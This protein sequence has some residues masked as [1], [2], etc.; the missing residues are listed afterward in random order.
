MHG[1]EIFDFSKRDGE[2][3]KTGKE[4]APEFKVFPVNVDTDFWDERYLKENNDRLFVE[5]H[6]RKDGGFTEFFSLL[7]PG[8]YSIT[9]KKY[10][11]SNEYLATFIVP[12]AQE[13]T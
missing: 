9:F 6:E 10:E 11:D 7:C 5:I 1:E 13:F 12:D 8:K 4:K 2:T 3:L